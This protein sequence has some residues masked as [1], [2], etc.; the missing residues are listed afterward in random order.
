ML[1]LF[2]YKVFCG[3]LSN[4]P[5]LYSYRYT[6]IYIIRSNFILALGFLNVIHS[7]PIMYTLLQVALSAFDSDASLDVLDHP[8]LNLI[9]YTVPTSL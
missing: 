2:S 8:V 7:M 4:I 5:S 3:K 1:H 6:Y 9:Y